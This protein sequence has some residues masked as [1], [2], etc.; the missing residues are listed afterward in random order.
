MTAILDNL[1]LEGLMKPSSLRTHE[2]LF[3][4]LSHVFIDYNLLDEAV[5]KYDTEVI[6]L[7]LPCKRQKR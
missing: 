5:Q 4:I 1:T 6:H 2:V 3:T 7:E